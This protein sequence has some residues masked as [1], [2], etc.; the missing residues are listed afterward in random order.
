MNVPDIQ[1]D[2]RLG[3]RVTDLRNFKKIQ[4]SKGKAHPCPYQA[5]KSKPGE[6]EI[7]VDRLDL[8]PIKEVAEVAE[9]I[10][11]Q[12]N[13]VFYGWGVII[14]RFLPQGF[15]ARPSPDKDTSNKYHASLYSPYQ[16]TD[17]SEEKDQREIFARQLA[18]KA[19]WLPCPE[20]E[21]PED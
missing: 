6:T 8:A 21:R 7:S 17:G 5:F 18:D 13:K 2:E 12:N 3:R 14:Y 4:A 11:E 10:T 20:I 15:S 19:T 9:R 1:D 16:V